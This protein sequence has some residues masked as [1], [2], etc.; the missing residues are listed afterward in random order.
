M[1]CIESI[2]RT[3]DENLERTGSNS[4]HTPRPVRRHVTIDKVDAE[5]LFWEF[6]HEAI[7]KF[8]TPSVSVCQEEIS[9]EEADLSPTV[10]SIS[11]G[12]D[13]CLTPTVLELEGGFRKKSPQNGNAGFSVFR[14]IYSRGVHEDANKHELQEL[15][16]KYVVKK[17]KQTMGPI[18]LKKMLFAYVT[19]CSDFCSQQINWH[20]S[21]DRRELHRRAEEQMISLGA[22]Q[23]IVQCNR[24]KKILQDSEQSI[25]FLKEIIDNDSLQLS[26]SDFFGDTNTYFHRV[27]AKL[28]MHMWANSLDAEFDS[29]DLNVTPDMRWLD[30]LQRDQKKLNNGISEGTF[31]VRIIGAI[32]LKSHNGEECNAYAIL[33]VKNSSV[34]T[35]FREATNEPEWSQAFKFVRFTF[36]KPDPKDPVRKE[37]G[38]I[39]IMNWDKTTKTAFKIGS[40]MFELPNEYSER[41]HDMELRLENT[42]SEDPAFI[43]FSYELKEQDH[44]ARDRAPSWSHS[45]RSRMGA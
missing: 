14:R 27:K 4:M 43:H 23:S 15:W 2:P 13:D 22:S 25:A 32:G 40:V 42:F 11:L 8:I 19:F 35:V 26:R 44:A 3:T 30:S 21:G 28:G 41:P 39:H 7:C 33:T 20:K 38:H 36:R 17:E 24:I 18:E 34:P 29:I 10:D 37:F 1:G 9:I 16:E 6:N 31:R 5:T 12:E 45:P